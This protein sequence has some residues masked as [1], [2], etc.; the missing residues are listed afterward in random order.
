MASAAL[1]AA[2]AQLTVID[3]VGL[4]ELGSRFGYEAGPRYQY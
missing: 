3:D 4:F 2:G 1:P